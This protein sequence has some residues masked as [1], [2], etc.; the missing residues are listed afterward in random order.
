VTRQRRLSLI[1][2]FGR[3][4]ENSST[5]RGHAAAAPARARVD[6]RF[7]SGG[8]RLAGLERPSDQPDDDGIQCA[9]RQ[10]GL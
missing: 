6:F 4:T 7:E 10:P 2:A 8:D 3:P 5:S 9:R 1:E